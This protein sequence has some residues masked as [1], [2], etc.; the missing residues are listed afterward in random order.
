MG[1]HILAGFLCF[2]LLASASGG[3]IEE[4]RKTA[5]D[6][7]RYLEELQ[8]ENRILFAK[9]ARLE[10]EVKERTRL[11]K[12]SKGEGGEVCGC[13]PMPPEG[14]EGDLRPAKIEYLCPDNKRSYI[15]GCRSGNCRAK[16]K[17]GIDGRY[18]IGEIV[19]DNWCWDKQ[20]GES[21]FPTCSQPVAFSSDRP[22]VSEHAGILMVGGKEPRD[23]A[24]WP[25]GSFPA[26]TCANKVPGLGKSTSRRDLRAF[27]TLSLIPGSPSTLV[28]CGGNT[29]G[30]GSNCI[31]WQNGQAEWKEY[32]LTHYQRGMGQA[33]TMADGSILLLGGQIDPTCGHKQRGCSPWAKN[34]TVERVTPGKSEVVFS[35]KHG[36]NKQGC[37]VQPVPGGE[38]VLLGGGGCFWCPGE[39]HPHVERYDQTGHLGSLPDMLTARFEHACGFFSDATGK[40]VLLVAGGSSNHVVKGG[41]RIANTEILLP[42]ASSWIE[43]TPLP[44]AMSGIRAASLP[45]GSGLL[46]TGM[47]TTILTYNLAT[48]QWEKVGCL[49]K[50]YG[51]HATL[52]GDLASLCL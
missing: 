42:G 35:I 8:A 37:A 29:V 18:E 47:D 25:L 52:A 39:P 32:A 40:P 5:A 41:N 43:A 23:L 14:H 36:D 9:A 46:L 11:D 19:E 13:L 6:L 17:I 12:S 21:A 31:S 48:Q 51:L 27:F 26:Q 30:N 50:T 45:D 38:V 16:C 20:E 24:G 7:D 22:R 2:F 49:E 28:A 34:Q 4:D 15:L 44:K 10:K 3:T 33:A 1:K